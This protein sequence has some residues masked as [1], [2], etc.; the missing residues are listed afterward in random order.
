MAS[1]TRRVMRVA[2]VAGLVGLVAVG[3]VGAAVYPTSG[4][5]YTVNVLRRLVGGTIKPGL[6]ETH[7]A[8]VGL[9]RSVGNSVDAAGEKMQWNGG[10]MNDG[11][12]WATA[13]Y[14]LPET[15][16]LKQFNHSYIPGNNTPTSYQI[17]VS[18]T[19][20]GALTP[21]VTSA[22]A[23]AG[24]QI[25][26][27][28]TPVSAR[29]VQYKWQ[30]TNPLY[31]YV[32][33]Q[34]FRAYADASTPV[35]PNTDD[36]YDLVAFGTSTAVKVSGPWQTDAATNITDRDQFSYLRGAGGGDAIVKVD[37]GFLHD[38]RAFSL[39]YYQ[40][41]TWSS[42][43][44]IEVSA[45]DVSYTTLFNQTTTLASSQDIFTSATVGRYIRLTDYNGTTG[46]L[47]DLQVFGLPEPGG[48]LLLTLGLGG[49]LRR[50]RAA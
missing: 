45:D 22:V 26:T 5:V 18:T 14:T 28:A 36:G 31:Q 47:S 40:D 25:D 10:T 39:G 50:R 12:K 29:Y 11:T 3:P 2:L 19:G 17:S 34:E 46:A 8:T 24:N 44:K 13:Q 48:A 32:M 33:L 20:F 43:A 7:E 35:P 27:L 37:L 21:V 30:G 6:S 1:G 49:L 15:C 42:G 38:I 23:P 4:G 16:V 41:Q 9:D